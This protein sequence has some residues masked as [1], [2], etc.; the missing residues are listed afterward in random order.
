VHASAC[1]DVFGEGKHAEEVVSELVRRVQAG[2]AAWEEVAEEIRAN[3]IQMLEGLIAGRAIEEHLE[4]FYL[5]TLQQLVVAAVPGAGVALEA[6]LG[7]QS[8]DEEAALG[9]QSS[10]EDTPSV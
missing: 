9:Q 1:A 8:S 4:T 3:E 5:L 2:T 7:Q 6:E 10:D